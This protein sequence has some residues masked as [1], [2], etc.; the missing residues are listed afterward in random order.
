MPIYLNPSTT[1]K[2]I[3]ITSPT[4]TV[5]VQTLVDTIRNWENYP[6]N[7]VYK[8]PIEKAEG[9]ADVGDSVI[10]GIIL[11]LSDEWRIKF[12]S[13]VGVGFIKDGTIVTTSGYLSQPVEPTGGSDTIIVNN[14]IG[15]V[16]A[17]TGS[18]VTEQD[19]IDIVDRVWDEQINSHSQVGSTGEALDSASSGSSPSA[20]ADAVW[21]ETL[22]D[23]LGAGSTGEKLDSGG[24][25]TPSEIATA[26]WDEDL[27]TH[28]I[29]NSAGEIVLRTGRALTNKI[30]INTDEDPVRLEVWDEAGTTIVFHSPLYDKDNNLVKITAKGTAVNRGNRV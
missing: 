25:S 24:G 21:D 14:Q 8:T 4:T 28:T 3:H 5:T 13:G 23:H 10:S 9:K 12:W 2:I 19:K 17:V 6:N 26:V 11:T 29:T 18:G 30:T 16:I 20:I 27:L 1:P 15:G 22:A 7:F